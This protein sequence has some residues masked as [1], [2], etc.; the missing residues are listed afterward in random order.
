MNFHYRTNFPI[1]FI[2]KNK[3]IILEN[4]YETVVI[5]L[6]IKFSFF[7]NTE[8]GVLI[9]YVLLVWIWMNRLWIGMGARGVAMVTLLGSHFRGCLQA[10]WNRLL[11]QSQR[12]AMVEVVS[13][14]E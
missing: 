7:Q 6:G 8:T 2:L 4:N 11:L 5:I 13:I 14:V 1:F 12:S 3:K 10:T 9:C